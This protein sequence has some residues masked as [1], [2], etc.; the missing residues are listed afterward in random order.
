MRRTGGWLLQTRAKLVIT[1]SE[2]VWSLFSYLS[3]KGYTQERLSVKALY[4]SE[5]LVIFGDQSCHISA[6]KEERGMR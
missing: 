2:N 5:A 1:P 3:E 6:L 4:L